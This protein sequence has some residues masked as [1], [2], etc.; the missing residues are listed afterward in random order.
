MKSARLF[1]L[2]G[3]AL[4]LL[5]LA[6]PLPGQG[7]LFIGKLLELLDEAKKVAAQRN[8]QIKMGQDLVNS[9]IE[10]DET[11]RVR[12]GGVSEG[13]TY[14]E[15][16]RDLKESINK[17]LALAREDSTYLSDATQKLGLAL[18]RYTKNQSPESLTNAKGL[19]KLIN[20]YQSNINDRMDRIKSW[21]SQLTRIRRDTAEKEWDNPEGRFKDE[22]QAMDN[23]W[24]LLSGTTNPF[25]VNLQ[26]GTW[27][28]TNI[29]TGKT[30]M[31]KLSREGTTM[32]ATIGKRTYV[33]KAGADPTNLTFTCAVKTPED[34]NVI[35]GP[36][37]RQVLLN[38]IK[39]EPLTYVYWMERRSATLLVG[40]VKGSYFIQWDPQ[41]MDVKTLKN[42]PNQ[43]VEWRAVGK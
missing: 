17:E 25:S 24:N 6:F 30:R 8:Q 39:M 19:V 16:I 18:E 28:E 27:E 15:Q 3:L 13:R 32:K 40:T 9:I 36:I 29:D 10:D 22:R 7:Q 43:R 23:L 37:P 42:D 26:A 20:H 31:I 14:N 5:T 38:A 34:V 33:A 1:L 2:P 35:E 12:P 11:G 4:V 41:T 21:C